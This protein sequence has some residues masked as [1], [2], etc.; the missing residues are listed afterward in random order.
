ME[1]YK[2]TLKKRKML[3]GAAI[4]LNLC[5]S[6]F[7]MYKS[8]VKEL[9][10]NIANIFEFLSGFMAGLSIL[11][12]VVLLRYNRAMSDSRRMKEA[13]IKENDE[14]LI[15]VRQKSGAPILI[16]TSVIMMLAGVLAGCFNSTVF[17][18][19]VAAAICQLLLCVVLKFYYMHKL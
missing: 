19:L 12:A 17:C 4:L 13:Y 15:L 11:L 14:R 3:Y 1:T 5:L 18:T 16:I 6:F 8:G 2:K 7:I 10:A 9:P